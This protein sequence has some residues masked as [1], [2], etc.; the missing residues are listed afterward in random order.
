MCGSK[1]VCVCVEMV[2]K[3]CV[4]VC[5]FKRCVLLLCAWLG[6]VLYGD[7]QKW[8]C[9]CVCSNGVHVFKG[10][11]CRCLKGVHVCVF[12]DAYVCV[13]NCAWLCVVL[14]VVCDC[15]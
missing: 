7:V 14:T 5:V 10:C 9:K 15:V 11:M 12:K 3:G 13:V 8:L 6:V 4:C 2:F 1:S